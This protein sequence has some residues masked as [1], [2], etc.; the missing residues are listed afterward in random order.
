[1]AFAQIPTATLFPTLQDSD[2]I[3]G[4][5]PPPA[6]SDNITQASPLPTP[7]SAPASTQAVPVSTGAACIPANPPQTGKV[8]DILDGDTIKVMIEGKTYIVRYI[9][10]NAPE[11]IK[12]KEFYSTEATRANS[13]LV[14]AKDI[15]LIMATTNADPSGRLL[16]Y[17]KVGD[18]F[19][20]LELVTHGYARAE[21]SP[22]DTACDATFKTAENQAS[23]AKI[24]I[25]GK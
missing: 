18:I 24:G 17:V 3:V 7:A 11:F 13:K 2:N 10:I 5:A 9:G 15:T 12:S 16:R 21:S 20:N 19:V 1:M 25:W 23:G 4:T 6:P 14:F 22:P 8:L